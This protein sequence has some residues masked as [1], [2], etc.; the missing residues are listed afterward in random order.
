MYDSSLKHK[1]DNKNVRDYAMKEAMEKGMQIGIEKGME[2]GIKQGE[3][4]KVLEIAR[5]CKE[6]GMSTEN[7]ARG[8]GLSIEEIES[9]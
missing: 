4:K 9:L 6:I 2:I 5:A 3:R 7:I 8:T 1:W